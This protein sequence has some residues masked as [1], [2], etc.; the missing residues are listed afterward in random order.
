MVSDGGSGEGSS[1]SKVTAGALRHPRAPPRPRSV[2]PPDQQGAVHPL[3]AVL[4]SLTGR[5]RWEHSREFSSSGQQRD[6][7]STLVL[8][9]KSQR[10]LRKVSVG[11]G[12][13]RGASWSVSSDMPSSRLAPLETHKQ[14]RQVEATLTLHHHA[15][16]EGQQFQVPKRVLCPRVPHTSGQVFTKCGR[17]T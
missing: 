14:T 7:R 6:S 1:R 4:A 16:V 10:A 5:V 11:S 8:L 9:L 17:I 13:P 15:T 12:G 3:C 2:P